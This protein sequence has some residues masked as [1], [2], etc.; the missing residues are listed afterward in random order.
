MSTPNEDPT[1]EADH[2]GESVR[3][4]DAAPEKQQN[5]ENKSNLTPNPLDNGMNTMSG[6]ALPAVNVPAD[7]GKIVPPLT[8]IEILHGGKKEWRE[9]I[10]MAYDSDS[11]LYNVLFV[12]PV[13]A[14]SDIHTHG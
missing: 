14:I 1:L 6:K 4:R 9:A 12:M 10:V 13:Y 7:A 3:D 8:K 11:Q 5:D 2:A